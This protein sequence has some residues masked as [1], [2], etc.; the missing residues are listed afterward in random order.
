MT[1]N[2]D[3]EG[4][5]NHGLVPHH[6]GPTGG[7]GANQICYFFA[8]FGG[9]DGGPPTVPRRPFRVPISFLK[10]PCEVPTAFRGGFFGLAITN[11]PTQASQEMQPVGDLTNRNQ[12]STETFKI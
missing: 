1:W 3:A 12:L 2:V 8:S 7:A 10:T 5:F 4:L 11:F 6:A 9:F